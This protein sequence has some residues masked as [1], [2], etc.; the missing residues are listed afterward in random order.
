MGS[1]T[2]GDR[3]LKVELKKVNGARPW[4]VIL[5]AYIALTTEELVK[6]FDP[7]AVLQIPVGADAAAIKRAYRTLSLQY[8]P[9]GVAQVE[10]GLKVPESA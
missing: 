10:L 2:I 8:H 9:G 5:V 6:V 1:A 7:Y 4:R 3:R